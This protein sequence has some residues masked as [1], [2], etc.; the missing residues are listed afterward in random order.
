MSARPTDYIINPAN[1]SDD[2][3]NLKIEQLLQKEKLFE[4]PNRALSGQVWRIL[5]LEL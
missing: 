1:E 4:H 2:H 3:I 5:F